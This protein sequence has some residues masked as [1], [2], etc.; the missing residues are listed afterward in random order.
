MTKDDSTATPTP[1]D[2]SSD[3]APQITNYRVTSD[4]GVIT[5]AFDS[6]ENLVDIEADVRGP[7]DSTLTEEDFSGDR[8]EGFQATFEPGSDGYYTVELVTTEDSSGDDGAQGEDF[9][10]S[11][12]LESTNE[13]TDGS[14][15]DSTDDSSSN[16]TDDSTDSSGDSTD[17]SSSDSTDDSSG[18]STDDSS[19]DSTDDSTDDSSSDSSSDDTGESG[20]D[21]GDTGGSDDGMDGTE[22]PTESDG[23]GPGPVVAVTALL[24]VA[25][26]FYRRR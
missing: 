14:T 25:L 2:D 20:D 3:D 7:E 17:D 16:S 9:T 15:D 13:S 21:G 22:A 6:D 11:T 5:V 23:P 4:G 24:A 19:S 8:F 18:D 1:T 12:T 26:L 10:D